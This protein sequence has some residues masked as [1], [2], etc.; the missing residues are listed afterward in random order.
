MHLRSFLKLMS[1]L[2]EVTGKSS[3][4]SEEDNFCISSDK[5]S[6]SSTGSEQDE[7]TFLISFDRNSTGPEQEGAISA[8]ILTGILVLVP[9]KFCS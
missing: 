1:G 6:K 5:I 8:S 3:T 4:S 7:T 2:S 9:D